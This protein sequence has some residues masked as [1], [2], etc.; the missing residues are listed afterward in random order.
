M[1]IQIAEM[2]NLYNFYIF[3]FSCDADC[4]EELGYDCTGGSV[5]TADT[6]S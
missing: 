3:I 6:C 5:S 2:G 1:A 4:S